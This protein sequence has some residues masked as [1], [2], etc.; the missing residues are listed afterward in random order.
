MPNT[1]V[2]DTFNYPGGASRRASGIIDLFVAIGKKM[3]T[4]SEQKKQKIRLKYKI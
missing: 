1:I 2:P 4:I 3:D